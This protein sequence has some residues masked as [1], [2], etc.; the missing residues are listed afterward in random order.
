LRS[1]PG[2]FTAFF[3]MLMLGGILTWFGCLFVTCMLLE[4]K[5]AARSAGSTYVFMPLPVLIYAACV[6]SKP[7]KQTVAAVASPTGIN[8]SAYWD[9][10]DRFKKRAGPITNSAT[11]ACIPARALGQSG[12][13]PA[14]N[15]RH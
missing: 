1:D 6:P 4:E 15:T 14:L 13:R 7:P 11:P 5:T 9:A 2:L 10:V 3:D 12:N 8:N